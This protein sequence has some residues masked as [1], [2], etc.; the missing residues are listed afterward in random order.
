MTTSTD[1][2]DIDNTQETHQIF[3]RYTVFWNTRVYSL[4]HLTPSDACTCFGHWK[5]KVIMDCI[6]AKDCLKLSADLLKDLDD[7][8]YH[9]YLSIIK[10]YQ[11][12]HST[13]KKQQTSHQTTNSIFSKTCASWHHSILKLTVCVKF[14]QYHSH[15]WTNFNEIWIKTQNISFKTMHFKNAIGYFV[16][17]SVC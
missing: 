15:L 3:I 12:H 4:I 10:C 1:R 11:S 14:G 9:S 5:K 6:T 7:D 13:I 8:C 17:A 2:I 16:Q